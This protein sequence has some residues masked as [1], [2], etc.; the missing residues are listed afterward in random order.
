MRSLDYQ[1]LTGCLAVTLNF[2]SCQCSHSVAFVPLRIQPLNKREASS[3]SAMC[4]P[5]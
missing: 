2:Y 5:I 4:V 3:F 1:S